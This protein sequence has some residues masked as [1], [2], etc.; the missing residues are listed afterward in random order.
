[1]D[2]IDRIAKG[3]ARTAAKPG[4]ATGDAYL[5]VDAET[6]EFAVIC[7]LNMPDDESVQ[8]SV[9]HLDD[10]RS[11]VDAAVSAILQ[12]F[13]G[14]SRTNDIRHALGKFKAGECAYEYVVLSNARFDPNGPSAIRL[15]LDASVLMSMAAMLKLHQMFPSARRPEDDDENY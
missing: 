4:P 3:I 8:S 9:S 14:A 1:M 13:H 10:A 6:G 12:A 15:L 2:R 7:R 11:K 5:D